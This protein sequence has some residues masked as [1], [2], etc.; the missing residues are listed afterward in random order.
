MGKFGKNDWK[1]K[2]YYCVTGIVVIG[3]VAA[4][5][6][7]SPKII[8]NIKN[9][10]EQ[11]DILSDTEQISESN[12]NNEVAISEVTDTPTAVSTTATPTYIPTPEP[13]KASLMVTA[14]NLNEGFYKVSVIAANA[15]STISQKGTDNSPMLL[16]DGRDDTTWQE[17][18]NGYGI[19]ESVSFSFDTTH[20]IKYIGFKLG[21]WKNDKYYFG[22]AMPKTMTLTFGN[23]SG[24]VTFNGVRDIEWVEVN[25]TVTADSMRI[26]IDDVYPGTSWEDTCITEIMVYAKQ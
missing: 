25:N 22:N 2:V 12:E 23:Y 11:N 14:P 8:G 26:T 13:T 6:I 17:G 5:G 20:Q 21:N 4:V 18:V 3:I 9:V 1:I 15:T 24:Q 16:F 19:N 7:N 10:L